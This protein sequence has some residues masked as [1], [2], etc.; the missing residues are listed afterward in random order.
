MRRFFKYLVP[1]LLPAVLS[2]AAGAQ[3]KRCVPMKQDLESRAFQAGERL[4]YNV[5]CKVGI[6]NA[7]VARGYFTMDTL[8]LD[9]TPVYKA[10]I[11]GKTAKFYDMFFKIREDFTSWMD[12]ETLRPVLFQRDTR[13]GGY[14]A[15]DEYVY[16]WD[17]P[18]YID[19]RL[20]SK[21][22]GKREMKLS[23]SECTFD[24]IS[25]FCRLRNADLDR[26]RPGEEF[27]ISFVLGSKAEYG[28][29]KYQG[30]ETL[31]TKVYGRV[32]AFKFCLTL[33]K[34]RQGEP[35]EEDMHLWFSDDDNRVPLLFI[36]PL[37]VGHI[38]G[39]LSSHSGLRHP[40]VAA[41]GE[42]EREGTE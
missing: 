18:P 37:K 20:D 40:F 22:K 6:V 2:L 3:P 29:L 38:E 23:L 1:V 39:R 42:A 19:A 26:I 21:N 27:E 10:R 14:F 17:N 28:H 15:K 31:K 36:A 11:E 32:S 12:V 35:Q 8:R 5:H 13:E 7:D 41:Q 34:G 4:V 30:R 16:R 33:L 9:G 24:L 25:L